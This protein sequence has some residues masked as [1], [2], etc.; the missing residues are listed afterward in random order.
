M[1]GGE[2]SQGTPAGGFF[3]NDLREGVYHGPRDPNQSLRLPPPRLRSGDSRNKYF[4][5]CG[6]GLA[7]PRGVAAGQRLF[8]WRVVGALRHQS[9][10]G[11][12][13]LPFAGV[14]L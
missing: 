9:L 6:H 12:G 11:L 2:S 10:M 5:A 13:F 7:R 8:I 14:G 1:Q 3:S 4:Q